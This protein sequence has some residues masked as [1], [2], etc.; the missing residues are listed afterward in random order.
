MKVLKLILFALL[1]AAPT[2]AQASGEPT[3]RTLYVESFQGQAARAEASEGSAFVLFGPRTIA[4]LSVGGTGDVIEATWKHADPVSGMVRVVKVTHE[5]GRG[6]SAASAREELAEL[7]EIFAAWYPPNVVAPSTAG[8]HVQGGTLGSRSVLA[9]FVAGEDVTTS[10]LTAS[11]LVPGHSSTLALQGSAVE[12]LQASW[13]HDLDGSA[14]PLEPITI[15]AKVE[16][17]A[18]ESTASA[19]KRLAR[20]VAELA[21][22]FP[23]NVAEEGTS[24]GMFYPAVVRLRVA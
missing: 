5:R 10:P 16:K 9:P 4:T 19:A 1:C 23:P 7:V 12:T 8:L 3:A 21:E 18:G 6:Q 15:T 20:L 13:K 11:D 22:A 24:V 14:G 2:A 17:M